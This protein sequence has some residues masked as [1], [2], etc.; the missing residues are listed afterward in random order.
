MPGRDQTGPQGQGPG[1]GRGLGGCV[2]RIVG[3]RGGGLGRGRGA[4]RGG[5]GQRGWRNRFFAT[6]L[7]GWQRGDVA[8]DEV[9]ALK[10]E[11]AQLAANLEQVQQ[12]LDAL[13]PKDI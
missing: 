4:G 2:T 7:P 10:A 8:E 9:S 11:A 6:G 1:T 5:G 13:E 3:G 12:R